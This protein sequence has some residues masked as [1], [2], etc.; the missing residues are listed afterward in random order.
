M[1]LSMV[2]AIQISKLDN[3]EIIDLVSLFLFR[4]TD[5]NL[6]GIYI[7]L[8]NCISIFFLPFYNTLFSTSI[9]STSNI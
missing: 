8:Q 4:N 5:I 7:I 3:Q 6:D 9:K 2:L 1:I